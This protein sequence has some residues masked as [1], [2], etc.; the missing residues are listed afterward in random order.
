MADP[1]Q[2]MAMVKGTP[3]A[4]LLDPAAPAQRAGVLSS[5]N[6]IAD[7]MELLPEW[8]HKRTTF[9]TRE[10]RIERK[11]WVFLTSSAGYREKSFAASFG[12]ARPADP[13]YARSLRG[14]TCEAG[15]VCARRARVLEQA[16]AAPHGSDRKPQVRQSR[17][18]RFPGTQSA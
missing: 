9:A 1:D 16:A 8:E 13:A 4:A 5:L 17:R 2:L 7:S 10:W 6:L 3:L 12:V 15:L 14:R 11:R 18:T